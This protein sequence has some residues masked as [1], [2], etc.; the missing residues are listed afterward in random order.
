M[1]EEETLKVGVDIAD[2][3]VRV[4]FANTKGEARRLIK[5][6][7]IRI[8]DIVVPDPFARLARDKEWLMIWD[9]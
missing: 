5:Q 8:N 7:G 3:C 4:G 6:G 9:K 1:V 2:L